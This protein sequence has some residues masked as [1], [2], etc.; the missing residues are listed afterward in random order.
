METN[1]LVKKA[2]EQAKNSVEKFGNWFN[3]LDY[4][5]Q[6]VLLLEVGLPANTV[7]AAQSVYYQLAEPVLNGC[8][9]S[10]NHIGSNNLDNCH[11][12]LMPIREIHTDTDRF[13]NRK[14]AFSEISAREVAENYDPN[15]FDPIVVWYDEAQEKYLVI[16]G[17]SRY[18]GMKRR[19]EKQIPVRV[20][21]GT[22]KAAIQFAKVDANRGATEEN[23]T[24]DI[25]AYT[26]MRDGDN[27]KGIAPA[28]KKEIS[29]VF[30]GKASKLENYSYLNPNGLFIE[31]MSVA[32]KTEFPYIERFA[33]WAGE[34][35]KAYLQL[36][37]THEDDIFYFFYAG[38][39]KSNKISKQDFEKE[40]QK[41]VAWGKP[42]LFPE[43]SPSDCK[44]AKQLKEQGEN[45][46]LYKQLETLQSDLDKIT[47]RLQSKSKTEKVYTQEER[48]V[49][50]RIGN[51]IQT[52]QKQI[53][54]DLKV[55][56][57][58]KGLF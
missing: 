7:Q 1:Q 49:L 32:N 45:K 38:D 46:A 53:K 21:E 30:K 24:E 27:T 37:N 11:A 2:K 3:N 43:C 58:Q 4:Y 17:H 16:S 5:Y 51:E 6:A 35:R 15:K 9:D 23:L 14:D 25:E 52:Q 55:L 31:K 8:S 40:I 36:T 47:K 18:E 10:S 20:F 26:L 50:T 12:F 56:D 19:G 44:P 22:E 39:G 57:K 48:E 13:Q 29:R 41:R 28:S 42:R 34:V 54:R 33:S